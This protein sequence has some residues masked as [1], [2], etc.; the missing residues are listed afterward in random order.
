MHRIDGPGATPANTFTE[1]NPTTGQQATTVTADWLNAIQAEIISVLTAAGVAPNKANNGQLLASIIAL[2]AGGGVAVTAAGVTVADPG[3]FFDGEDVEAALEQLAVKIYTGTVNASQMRR[4]IVTLVGAAH[5]SQ[6]AHAENIV[7][8]NNAAT[9]VYTLRTD[10]DYNAPVGTAITLAQVGAGKITVVGAGGVTVKKPS[11][12]NAAT[13]GQEATVVAYKVAAN[14]WR[15]GGM[16]E[17][18]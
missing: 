8:I 11:S 13:L 5:S 1:G 14:T 2:I 4:T 9:I 10:A 6:A 12:F 17:A 16:L 7:E 3:D 15:L 18:T